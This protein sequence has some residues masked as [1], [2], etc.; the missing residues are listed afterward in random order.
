MMVTTAKQGQRQVEGWRRTEP[1]AAGYPTDE[2]STL[3]IV[4]EVVHDGRADWLAEDMRVVVERALAERGCDAQGG[5]SSA[6]TRPLWLPEEAAT[7]R[8]A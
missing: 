7:T 6:R 1:D 4:V 2:D 5:S 3:T 8:G